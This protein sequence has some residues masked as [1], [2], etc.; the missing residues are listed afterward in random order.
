MSGT[1]EFHFQDIPID[2]VDDG[3]EFSNPLAAAADV[4]IDLNDDGEDNLPAVSKKNG[5]LPRG[6]P[7]G[8]N[9]PSPTPPPS[10][11]PDMVEVQFDRIEVTEEADGRDVGVTDHVGGVPLANATDFFAECNENYELSWDEAAHR[12]SEADDPSRPPAPGWNLAYA[13]FRLRRVIESIYFRVFTLILIL[14]DI[15]LVLVDIFSG[16]AGDGGSVLMTI[17]LVITCYFVVEICLRILALT[18][19]VFFSAWYNVVDFAVVLCTFVVVAAAQVPGNAWSD[20]WTLVSVLRLVRLVRFVRLYTEKKQVETAARQLVSQNKRRFQQ[21]GFDLDLTY[22]TP[23]IIA[24]SFPSSGLWALYR[25]PIG[26]VAA[27]LDAKHPGKYKVR[28]NKGQFGRSIDHHSSL[29]S[30]TIC[31]PNAPTT[32]PSS[33]AAWSAS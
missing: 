18:Q 8:E 3:R 17:D 15:T 19:K 24:T 29:A 32:S 33:T 31:V 16:N 28:V 6:W 13:R 23:R 5:D 7:G 26:K 22:V 27:F 20:K 9:S 4:E 25:N 2:A 12:I 21:D 14:L 11:R 1:G 10:S 30:C